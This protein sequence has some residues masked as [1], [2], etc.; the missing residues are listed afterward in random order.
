MYV[1]F[2]TWVRKL[3]LLDEKKMAVSPL[4]QRGEQTARG[5]HSNRESGTLAVG[6]RLIRAILMPKCSSSPD[7]LRVVSTPKRLVETWRFLL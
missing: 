3:H 5:E 4:I 7:L 2:A 6:R 1:Y